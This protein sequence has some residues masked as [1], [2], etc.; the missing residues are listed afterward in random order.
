MSI[1]FKEANET[2]YWL[3]LLSRSAYITNDDLLLSCEEIIKII[4]SILVTARKN[5]EKK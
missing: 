1:S 5:E 4:T 2:R 3:K